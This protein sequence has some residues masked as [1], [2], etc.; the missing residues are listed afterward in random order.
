MTLQN[1][2]QD[3]RAV[4]PSFNGGL[5]PAANVFKHHLIQQYAPMWAKEI[6]RQ[7]LRF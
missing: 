2:L 3:V 1:C 7:S 5:K 6:A 4:A